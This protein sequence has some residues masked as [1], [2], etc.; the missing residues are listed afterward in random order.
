MNG[1]QKNEERW[2]HPA[3]AGHILL[4]KTAHRSSAFEIGRRDRW[5][6]DWRK[7]NPEG[8][9]PKWAVEPW[10]AQLNKSSISYVVYIFI[11]YL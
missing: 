7:D 1:K 10:Q 6:D 11:S 4:K 8:Q 2:E 5:I 9:R 3:S